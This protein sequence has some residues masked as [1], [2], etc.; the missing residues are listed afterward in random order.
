MAL[1][2]VL[3]Y[4]G[5]LNQAKK[6]YDRALLILRKEHGPEHADVIETYMYLGDVHLEL[7]DYIQAKEYYNLA[8]P[9]LRKEFGPEDVD[10]GITYRNLGNVHR[11]LSDFI[12][13]KK[14]YDRA[15]PILLKSNILNKH[16]LVKMIKESL[17]KIK[18]LQENSPR[19]SGS[20]GKRP[21]G[22][23]HPGSVPAK[24]SKKI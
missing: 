24:R 16:C 13:A 6:S 22:S 10:V 15:L 7:S 14:C 11:N 4:L 5:E 1:G 8:L 12:Q 9:F 18:Q 21:T 23:G 19:S 3:Q 17:V 20:F 2:K